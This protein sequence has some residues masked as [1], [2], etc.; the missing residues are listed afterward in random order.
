MVVR[1][2]EVVWCRRSQ[3]PPPAHQRRAQQALGAGWRELD[4]GHYPMLTEPAAL[5][6]IIAGG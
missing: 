5:A 4:T 6:A 2:A 1:T 3:N